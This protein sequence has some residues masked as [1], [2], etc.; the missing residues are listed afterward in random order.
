MGLDTTHG[1]YNGGY[2]GFN[3]F[4]SVVAKAA[5]V[6]YPPHIKPLVCSDGDVIMEPDN[7]LI[8]V[9][10]T[11]EDYRKNNPGLSAFLFSNDCEGE[12]PP[13][14]CKQMA[15]EIQPLI[16]KIDNQYVETAKTYVVGCR[17]AYENNE[18]LVYH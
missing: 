3:L 5:G 14:L 1:A 16:H 4:R 9:P 8:Y 2:M 17:L 7:G 10:G 11:A 15:D 6:N 12:F 18:T 13:E